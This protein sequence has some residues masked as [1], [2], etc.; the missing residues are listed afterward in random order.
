MNGNLTYKSPKA[1]KNVSSKTVI[2]TIKYEPRKG[3]SKDYKA[4]NVAMGML[5]GFSFFQLLSLLFVGL[6]FVWLL[7]FYMQRSVEESYKRPL[8]SFGIGFAIMILTPIAAL[9]SLLTGVGI[10]FSLILMLVWIMALIFGKL[11]AA[12]MIGMKIVKIKDR[13]S[14]LRVYGAFA[15]GVLIYVLLTFIPVVGWIIKFV[16]TCIGIGAMATYETSLFNSL[17]KSKKI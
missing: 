16:L 17:R 11:M 6:F 15:L 3:A 5:A 8:Q 4:K 9:I 1:S 2:G 7:R 14:F 10:L 12:A 13:S